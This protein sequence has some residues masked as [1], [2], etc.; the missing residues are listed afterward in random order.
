MCIPLEVYSHYSTLYAFSHIN[1]LI[2]QAFNMNIKAIALTDL[3]SVSGSIEFIQYLNKKNKFNNKKIKPILGLSLNVFV[4]NSIK[5]LLLLARNINGWKNLVKIVNTTITLN[6]DPLVRLDTLLKHQ[7]D[8]ILLIK[9]LCDIDIFN[10]F[11][12]PKFLVST[13]TSI[14]CQI[15]VIYSSPVMYILPEDHKYQR[16]IIATNLSCS[17]KDIHMHSDYA[18]YQDVYEN[19]KYYLYDHDHSSD[20]IYDLIEDYKFNSN[21][22]IPTYPDANQ[23]LLNKCREGWSNRKINKRYGDDLKTKQVYIDRINKEIKIISDA[24]L[25]SYLLIVKDFMDYIR[26][27]N[28][29]GGL[30]GSAVGCLISYLIGICDIDPL[31]PDPTLPYSPDRELLFERF[32][33]IGRI[34]KDRISLAD[35]DIDMP[36]SFREKMIN[37]V[38]DRY[39][40]DKVSRLITFIRLDGKGAL[41]AA[42]R[43]LDPVADSFEVANDLTKSMIDATA[44]QDILQDIKQEKPDYTIIQYNI[45]T[46][47]KISDAYKEYKEVFDLAIN[48][49]DTITTH[50]KHAAGIIISNDSMMN[51]YP[52]IIDENDNLILSLDMNDAEFCGAVKYDFLGVAAYEKIGK[53]IEMINNNLVSPNV[54]IHGDNLCLM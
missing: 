22:D 10:D 17:I 54:N 43:F 52:C 34:S 2:D 1:K 42:F 15:P 3:H 49:S 23:V 16:F 37:Y 19:N 50:G 39:G 20:I 7:T 9:N 32:F 38:K 12:Q 35:I 45:D 5:K 11:N 48:I 36:I 25:S 47:P 29:Y 24:G 27:Q 8:L 14:K 51:N 31:V 18:K 44:V 33:N 46:I 28:Q 6:G 53:I 21:P 4:D 40:H 13:D 30:R 41:K 26:S